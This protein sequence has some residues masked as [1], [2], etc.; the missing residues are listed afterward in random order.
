MTTEDKNKLTIEQLEKL[1]N[2]ENSWDEQDEIT[3]LP[4]GE[5]RSKGKF[6]KKEVGNKKPLTFKEDLGGE[7][8]VAA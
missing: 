7:Y 6:S 1:L 8:G 3:I 2:K 4:N 5:I